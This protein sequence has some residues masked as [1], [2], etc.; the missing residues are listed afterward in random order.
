MMMTSGGNDTHVHAAVAAGTDND[1]STG[2]CQ[3]VSP[4]RHQY[5]VLS[6]LQ[7]GRMPNYRICTMTPCIKTKLEE[8]DAVNLF[9]GLISAS[10][11]IPLR[12]QVLKQSNNSPSMNAYQWQKDT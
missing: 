11:K 6:P 1:V 9:L 2:G 3:Y 4:R 10:S 12:G 5:G 7:S 8:P